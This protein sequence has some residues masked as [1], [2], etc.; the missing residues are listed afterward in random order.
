M[1]RR[2]LLRTLAVAAAAAPL[3]WTLAAAVEATCV[4]ALPESGSGR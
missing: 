1:R 2:A 3:A 4:C